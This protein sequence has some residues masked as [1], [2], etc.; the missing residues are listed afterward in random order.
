M[1]ATTNP[2]EK[3]SATILKVFHSHHCR[4]Q[5]TTHFLKAVALGDLRTP[6]QRGPSF[7]L[8]A[9]YCK[10]VG[11]DSSLDGTEFLFCFYF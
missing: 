9:K 2:E 5:Y 6:F 8:E 7:F 11:A 3:D 1:I 10:R 4:Q